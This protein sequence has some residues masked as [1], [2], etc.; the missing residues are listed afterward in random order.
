MLLSIREERLWRS[1]S[2]PNVFPIS[3]ATFKVGALSVK[4]SHAFMLDAWWLGKISGYVGV[5]GQCRIETRI[6]GCGYDDSRLGVG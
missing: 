2:H 1:G 6:A 4:M 3:E 5:D